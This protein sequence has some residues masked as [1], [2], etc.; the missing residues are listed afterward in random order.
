MLSPFCV[1]NIAMHRMTIQ[2]QQAKQVVVTFSDS[3]AW[4]MLDSLSYRELIECT[5]I[6]AVR[7]GL[8][9]FNNFTHEFGG[10]PS[11]YFVIADIFQKYATHSQGGILTDGNT[12]TDRGVK[13]DMHP[14][15]DSDIGTDARLGCEMAM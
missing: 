11:P 13:A 9:L 10:D 12:L 14:I 6:R 3:L 5:S 8:I 15:G 2:G 1:F 7:H 4:P